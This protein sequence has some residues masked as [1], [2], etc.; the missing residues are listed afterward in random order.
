[1]YPASA[2]KGDKRVLAKRASFRA[3]EAAGFGTDKR[4]PFLH[5]GDGIDIIAMAKAGQQ[6]ARDTKALDNDMLPASDVAERVQELLDFERAAWAKE[7]EHLQAARRLAQSD[8]ETL[9]QTIAER[10]QRATEA[11]SELVARDEHL[12]R[13]EE[14]HAEDAVRLESDQLR[15]ADLQRRVELLDQ[16]HRQAIRSLHHELEVEGERSSR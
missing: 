14:L 12:H 8:V 2:A 10:E 11:D 3:C 5:T 1:M 15:L 13:L 7:R 9:Q 4:Q 16:Q 6:P